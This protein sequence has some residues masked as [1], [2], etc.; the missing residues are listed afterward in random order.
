MKR[1]VILA[2][3]ALLAAFPAAAE[4]R[5][6]SFYSNS[7]SVPSV[8]FVDG[9][10]HK[11]TLADFKGKLVVVDFWATWCVPCRQEFPAFDRLQENLGGKAIL[12]LP[13]S[14]DRKGMPAVDRFYDETK[15][16][17]LGRYL[18][19]G[20]ELSDAM[21]VRGLPTTVII[22]PDGREIGRVEG[23]AD[24]DSPKLRQELI[25]RDGG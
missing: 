2:L 10:G 13:I 4:M 21:G 5:E 23:P 3:L 16:I 24:W 17:H 15:P 11:L 18:D 1:R 19:D 8:P 22:G 7:R 12:V 14:I 6:V 20:H 9:Q 25:K